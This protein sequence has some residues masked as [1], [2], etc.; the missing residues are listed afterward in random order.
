[1]ASH[2]AVRGNKQIRQ[3]LRISLRAA[4]MGIIYPLLCFILEVAHCLQPRM[5]D[6]S[7]LK[8]MKLYPLESVG[9]LSKIGSWVS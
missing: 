2:S 5:L 1:M 6:I 8:V 9:K 3:F 7:R 4:F